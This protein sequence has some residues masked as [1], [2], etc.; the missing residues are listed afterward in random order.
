MKKLLWTGAWA[1]VGAAVLGWWAAYA[2]HRAE[3][4]TD[5][6]ESVLAAFAQA[7]QAAEKVVVFEGL[8]HPV[9]ERELLAEEKRTKDWWRL[10]GESFYSAKQT[11]TVEQRKRLQG[12]ERSIAP[13]S[14]MKLCGGFHADYAVAWL[15][16]FGV[17][18]MLACF[19]CGEVRLYGPQMELT[20]DLKGETAESLRTFLREFQRERPTAAVKK[21]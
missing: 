10:H 4:S 14:G 18:E 9:S 6:R 5:S 15:G 12:V 16:K 8:P 11:L 21:S 20:G 3:E 17:Y 13:W 2:S 7:T 19:S 1:V